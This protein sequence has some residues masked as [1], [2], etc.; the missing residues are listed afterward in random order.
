MSRLG[1]VRGAQRSGEMS[2]LNVSVRDGDKTLT[3]TA[4]T[5]SD[6]G[7]YTCTATNVVASTKRHCFVDVHGQRLTA[8]LDSPRTKGRSSYI[9]YSAP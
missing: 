2:W 6:A 9:L 8:C 5:E 4:A 7:V 1:L 3:V